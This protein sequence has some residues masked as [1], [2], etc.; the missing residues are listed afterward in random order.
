MSFA[1]LLSLAL[2]PVALAPARLSADVIPRHYDLFFDVDPAQG[3][4]SGTVDI[5][6]EVRSPVQ[7]MPE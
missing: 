6:V 4:F 1:L 5:D 2:G 3:R 7:E